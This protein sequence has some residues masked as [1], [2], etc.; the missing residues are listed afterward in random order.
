VGASSGPERRIDQLDQFRPVLAQL[1]RDGERFSIVVL[2][3][4][5]FA[6]AIVSTAFVE[7]RTPQLTLLRAM[8]ATRGAVSATALLENLFTAALVGTIAVLLGVTASYLDPNR[9]NQISQIELKEL[10]LPVVLYTKTVLLTLF[11]GLLT[12]LA[13]AVRAY[14]AVRAS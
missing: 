1:Q 5:S 8:G 7:V 4:G 3:L 13:P 10:S 11:I 6:V 12:G 9:F 2:I 14:R